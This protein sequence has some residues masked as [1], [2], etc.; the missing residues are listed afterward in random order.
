MLLVSAMSGDSAVDS[1]L[2]IAAAEQYLR[3]Q[4]FDV[5]GDLAGLRTDEIAAVLS[6]IGG[7]LRNRTGLRYF[8][9]GNVLPPRKQNPSTGHIAVAARPSCTPSRPM[10]QI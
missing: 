7:S 3:A 10:M 8:D 6:P 4:G 2:S 5:P 9:P 1:I